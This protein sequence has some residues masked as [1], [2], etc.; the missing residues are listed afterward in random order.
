MENFHSGSFL[1]P[2]LSFWLEQ[3]VILACIYAGVYGG[4]VLCVGKWS[5]GAELIM[6]CWGMLSA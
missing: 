6:K 4:E 1:S 2:Y 3:S 5:L